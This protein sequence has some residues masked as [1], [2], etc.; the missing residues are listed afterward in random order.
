MYPF[1]RVDSDTEGSAGARCV[2][3]TP[4]PPRCR[5]HRDAVSLRCRRVESLPEL[6][7][8]RVELPPFCAA[9]I[10]AV[11]AVSGRHR[12][13]PPLCRLDAESRHRRVAPLPS[14]SS[15]RRPAVPSSRRAVV[16]PLLV[17]SCR[18]ATVPRCHGATEPPCCPSA[19]PPST[20]LLLLPTVGFYLPNVVAPSH[21][22]T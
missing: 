1:C 6:N 12:V 18:N 22:T 15:C 19:V 8:Y 17:P 5:W 9:A 7:S 20:M 2:H 10:A 11:I 16:P 21:R 3:G 14:R 13:T 4:H